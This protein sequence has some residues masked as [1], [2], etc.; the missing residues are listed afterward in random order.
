MFVNNCF[1]EYVVCMINV[2]C[3]CL[4]PGKEH[5]I[6]KAICLL[7]AAGFT[8]SL[9]AVPA[10]VPPMQEVIKGEDQRLPVK[11]E[12]LPEPVKKMLADE[13]YRDW[14]IAEAYM[15]Q[16]ERKIYEITLSRG[17]EKMVIKVDEKG[18]KLA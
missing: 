12:E 8:C 5:W 18:N 2:V 3:F 10:Q 11:P 17:Q 6:M 4:V 13:Q 15:V 9:Q 1:S 14:K 16:E 7:V